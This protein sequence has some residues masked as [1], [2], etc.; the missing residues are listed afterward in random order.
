MK[1]PCG[2]GNVLYFNHVNVS[3][4]LMILSYSFARTYHWGKLNKEYIGSLCYFLQLAINLQLSQ[5]FFK[6]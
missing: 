3:I 6:K 1:D 4:L 5:S 2:D